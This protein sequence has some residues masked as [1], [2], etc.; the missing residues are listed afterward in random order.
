MKNYWL[1]LGFLLIIMSLS[2]CGAE[3][4]CRG[5]AQNIKINKLQ[6]ERL[7]TYQINNPK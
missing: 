7:L 1:I 3:E 2:S 6:P 4:N 5:R